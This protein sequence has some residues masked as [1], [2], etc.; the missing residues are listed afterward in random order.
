M[1]SSTDGWQAMER[2][3]PGNTGVMNRIIKGGMMSSV[4]SDT[5][6]Y[7]SVGTMS[8]VNL[9]KMKLHQRG[10]DGFSQLG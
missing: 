4:N 8:S 7:L 9:D 2:G 6:S 10:Y 1:P 5:M 3:A